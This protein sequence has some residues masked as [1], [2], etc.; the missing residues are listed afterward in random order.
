MNCLVGIVFRSSTNEFLL[1][2]GGFKFRSDGPEVI[3]G[4]DERTSF[5]TLDV[6]DTICVAIYSSFLQSVYM[7]IQVQASA[8][9]HIGA[10]D[11]VRM[12]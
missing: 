12:T 10:Y 4:L 6:H 3:P 5:S 11:F 9:C 8:S 7:P 2:F 1:I